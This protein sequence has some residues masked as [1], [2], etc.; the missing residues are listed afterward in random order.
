MGTWGLTAFEN[1][2]ALDWVFELEGAAD[3]SVLSETFF[4]VNESEDDYL[5]ASDSCFA[6]AAAEV[7]AALGGKPSA[8]LPLE[9][10]K[11]VEGKG[12]PDDGLVS[13]AKQAIRAVLEDS[14]LKELWEESDEYEAWV[15]EV[16]GLLDRLG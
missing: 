11:W 14:E 1:D 3:I 16:E 12:E 4:L 15:S 7:V 6:L 5:D 9:V 2:D 13:D 10:V 8:D